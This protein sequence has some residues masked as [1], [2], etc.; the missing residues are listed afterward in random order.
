[1]STRNNGK[2][3]SQS[4]KKDYINPRDYLKYD[5]RFACEECSHYDNDNHKCSMGYNAVHHQEQT[6]EHTYTLGGH[7]ALCRFHEID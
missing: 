1:M 5:F 3:I 7:M 4:I 2:R 6:Q